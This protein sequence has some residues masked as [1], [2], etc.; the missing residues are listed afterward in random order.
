MG[1]ISQEADV[2]AGP[3]G[4]P[5]STA[6]ASDRFRRQSARRGSALGDRRKQTRSGGDDS[7]GCHVRESRDLAPVAA[8]AQHDEAPIER[9]DE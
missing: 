2:D 3:R 6:L 1:G 5:W 4:G 8:L 7:G 9:P